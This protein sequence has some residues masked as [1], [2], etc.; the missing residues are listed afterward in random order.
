MSAQT[1]LC[2]AYLAIYVFCTQIYLYVIHMHTI[3]RV[4]VKPY[5]NS[6]QN[7]ITAGAVKGKKREGWHTV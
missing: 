2:F 6:K 3:P 4:C 1:S 7:K 5:F